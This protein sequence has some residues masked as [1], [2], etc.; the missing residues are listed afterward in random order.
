MVVVLTREPSDRITRALPSRQLQVGDVLAQD[1][2]LAIDRDGSTVLDFELGGVAEHE[3]LAVRFE[4]DPG[5]GIAVLQGDDGAAP[6]PTA[7]Y[8]VLHNVTSPRSS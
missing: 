5:E 8:S 4:Q 7:E 1:Q 3:G 6:E 2:D